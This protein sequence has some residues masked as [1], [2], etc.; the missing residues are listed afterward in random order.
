MPEL[1]LNKELPLKDALRHRPTAAKPPVVCSLFVK[2][3]TPIEI[4]AEIK[5]TAEKKSFSCTENV[6]PGLLLN[7][8]LLYQIKKMQ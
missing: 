2:P 5:P 7:K 8:A 3:R 6:S 1:K 4:G